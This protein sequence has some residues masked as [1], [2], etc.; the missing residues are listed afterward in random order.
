MRASGRGRLRPPAPRT[1][2][3]AASVGAAVALLPLPYLVDRARA[4]GLDE[5]R[6]EILQQRTLDLVTR[7]LV[8]TVVVTVLSTLLGVV[9][10]LVVVRLDIPFRRFW[11]VA[12]ALPLAVPTYVAAFAWVSAQPSLAGLHGAVLVLVLTCYP[13]VFLPTVAALVRLDP[14]H[15][16]VARSLGHGRRTVLWRVTLPQLRPAVTAGALLVALYVLSDFGAVAMMRYE[17]FTFVIYGAYNAG[18]NPARAAILALV[19]LAVAGVVVAGETAARGRADL[20]RVGAGTP[21]PAAPAPMGRWRRPLALLPAGIL[22]ASIGFPVLS[23]GRRLATDVGSDVDLGEVGGALWASLRLALLAALVTTLLALPVGVLAARHRSRLTSVIER[24]TYVAH[25]L[26][27]IVVAIS[28]VHVGV[29]LL[30]RWY[31]QTP[32]LVLAYAVLFL[33]LAV[34][35]VRTAVEQSPVRHEEVA[36][37][38]GLA[39]LRA[40]VRVTVPAAAPGVA[41]GAALVFLAA[42]KELPATLLLHP[43]GM[44]TL[45]TGLW[46]RTG[47]SDYGGAAPY[48]AALVLFA[49]V[50]TA[51]LGWWSGRT[52]DAD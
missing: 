40:F 41:A 10:A 37:S 51:V 50:P 38:L 46:Q 52:V 30:A 2:L 29:T 17:V 9:A 49:A 12:L 16:E 24:S 35:S 47:V 33:P 31:Q 23:I 28:M 27:G 5:V 4:R 11:Q 20:A 25:A 42:M 44:Q 8:L 18:F 32:L 45:A 43:T 6:R 7:S 36:R 13:Y 3:L 21:R 1:L 48:A 22:A 39:P 15:E 34:G 14:A 26:P 19:L